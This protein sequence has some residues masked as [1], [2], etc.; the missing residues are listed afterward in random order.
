MSTPKNLTPETG[1][2]R[3]LKPEEIEKMRLRD[4]TLVRGKF[5]FQECPGGEVKFPYK[6]YGKDPMEWYRM[7][8]GQVYTIPLGVAKHLTDNCWYPE[9]SYKKQDGSTDVQA[10]TKKIHR[11]SFQSM[12][13]SD[14]DSVGSDETKTNTALYYPGMGA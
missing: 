9:Y 11:V 14:Y 4:R 12:E 7:V 6:R 5:H 10:V 3:R 13:F 2:R 8:D 1:E